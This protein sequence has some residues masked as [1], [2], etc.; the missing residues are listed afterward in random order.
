MSACQKDLGNTIGEPNSGI[1]EYANQESFYGQV[2]A[3]ITVECREEE[4]F[5]GT[6]DFFNKI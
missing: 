5:E 1:S 2:G 3:P 4:E 6:R